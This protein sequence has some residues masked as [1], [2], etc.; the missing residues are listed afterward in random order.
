MDDYRVLVSK[1]LLRDPRPRT[2]D[3]SHIL[4][5]IDSLAINP[6]QTGDY[7]EPDNDGRLVQIKIIGDF[8]LTFWADHAVKEVKVTHFERADHG[9][10]YSN[11]GPGAE[12]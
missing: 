2:R 7:E 11:A 3:R 5:F 10:G 12:D 9:G 1:E 6:H 4:D 8:A